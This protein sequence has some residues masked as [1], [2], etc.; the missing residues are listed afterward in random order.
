MEIKVIIS[1]VQQR[2]LEHVMFDIQEWLQNAI[3]FRADAAIDELLKLET[4]RLIND[5]TVKAIPASKDEI[6]LNSPIETARE[7]TLRIEA[8]GCSVCENGKP[9]NISPEIDAIFDEA[10]NPQPPTT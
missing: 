1:D 8:E 5:P 6:I 9:P 7:R 2:A 10:L 4:E 3:D